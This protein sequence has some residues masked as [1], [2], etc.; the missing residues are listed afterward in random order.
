MSA[1]AIAP[2]RT[3]TSTTTSCITDDGDEFC[4]ILNE[5]WT[6][7]VCGM[8]F[9]GPRSAVH[10][11]NADDPCSGCGKPRCPDCDANA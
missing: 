3:G 11:Y 4:H 1:P 5:N 6:A 8:P 9:N 2:P 10:R 7:T